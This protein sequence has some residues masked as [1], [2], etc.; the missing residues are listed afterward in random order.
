MSFES[1]FKKY[2]LFHYN[3]LVAYLS[4]SG[5]FNKNTLKAAL[6]YHLS[7]KHLARIRRGYYL[8]TNDYLP[9][10]HIE[11]DYLLIAGRMTDDAVI[12]Y[13]TAME[14]HALA[15]SVASIVYFNS[16][17]RIGL[18]VCEQG[19]YQQLNHP[20][21]LKPD[22][23]FLETKLHDRMGIDIRVTSIERTLVDCLHRPELSGGWEEIWRSFES[24]NFLDIKR[25]INYVVQLGNATTV[26]KVGFFLE[27]HQEQFAVKE[28]QL[29]QLAHHK[30]K[31]RHYMEK[32]HKG[33]VKSLQRWNLVVPLAVINKIWEEPSN[34]TL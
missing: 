10:T 21:Q 17:E 7:K 18:L 16:D 24:I 11:S 9:G 27:Q 3:E 25:V 13:H 2:P 33:P 32:A 19:Q 4:S 15:Y 14:F 5:N 26:A 8:V 34:D 20:T 1:F 22:N 31:S 29:N 28:E 23:L 30:P 12:S 6:H